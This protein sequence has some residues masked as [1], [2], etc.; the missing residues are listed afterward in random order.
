M[1]LWV[2]DMTER[3]RAEV[4]PNA[5]KAVVGAAR[6][7][8]RLRDPRGRDRRDRPAAR[9]CT[10]RCAMPGRPTWAPEGTDRRLG[11]APVLQPLPR[12]HQSTRDGV[13]DRRAGSHSSNPVAHRSIGTREHDGPVWSRDGSKMAF[14]MDGVM[15][16][17]PVTPTGEVAG[18]PRQISNEVADSPSWAADSRRLLYQTADRLEAGRRRRR[19]RHRRAGQPDLDAGD[20][21]GPHRRACRPAVRRPHRRRCAAD[22]DIVIRDNRIEQVVEHRADLHTG[23]VVDAGNDVVM[24]GLDRDARAS[25]RR[26]TAKRLAASGWRTAS[27]RCEIP[28]RMHSKSLE[29]KEAIGAGV[30]HRPPHVHDRRTVRRFAHLLL[31]RRAADLR[32]AAA[33]GAAEDHRARLRPDQDLCALDDRLQKHVIDFAHANGM[34]VTSHEIY[35]A[36]AS[37]ADGVEHIRG[38]SRRGYSPKVTALYR[39]YQDVDRPADRV[40]DD[41]HADDRHHGRAFR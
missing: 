13:A 25:L 12:R 17:M 28:R 9:R 22:V 18:A 24:P 35:P 37:G 21:A 3:R 33:A 2:R 34:P 38:T 40:E 30:R 39:S 14:V 32:H 19:P 41:D 36:V 27:R 31:R 23:R 7:R 8:D 16:V 26:T 4:A 15:H 29:D 6:Q 20:P 10:R 11:A 1:D 5:T